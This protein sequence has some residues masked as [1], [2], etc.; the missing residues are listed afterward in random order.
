MVY[1]HFYK[2]LSFRPQACDVGLR[3]QLVPFQWRPFPGPG[4][5]LELG[6]HVLS[7]VMNV[8]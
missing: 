4:A 7:T 2:T 5:F 3:T 1:G 6:L 8:V